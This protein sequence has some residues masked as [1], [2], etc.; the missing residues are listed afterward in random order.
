MC[1]GFASTSMY[2]QRK[3][4]CMWSRYF[5]RLLHFVELVVEHPPS[6][7]TRQAGFP[8]SEF[9]CGCALWREEGT[10]AAIRP[11]VKIDLSYL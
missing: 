8:G 9:A 5:A 11:E 1:G 2:P 6:R 10:M 3:C 7:F 4:S